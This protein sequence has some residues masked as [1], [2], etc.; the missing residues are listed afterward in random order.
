MAVNCLT[1]GLSQV[2]TYHLLKEV[3]MDEIT[4]INAP[5]M[6]LRHAFTANLCPVQSIHGSATKT[7]VAINNYDSMSTVSEPSLRQSLA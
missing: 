6:I 5:V 2:A 4:D 3:K 1:K 7:T